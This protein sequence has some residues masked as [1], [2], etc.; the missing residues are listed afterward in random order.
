MR[1]AG[2]RVRLLRPEAL[3]AIRSSYMETPYHNARSL[4]ALATGTVVWNYIATAA[5]WTPLP[6]GWTTRQG[7][8]IHQASQ[9]ALWGY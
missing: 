4:E 9:Q 8:S 5:I 6:T 2:R 1:S 7:S 3:H